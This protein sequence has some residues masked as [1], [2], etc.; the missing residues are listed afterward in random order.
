MTGLLAVAVDSALPLNGTED[1]TGLVLSARTIPHQDGYYGNG[2]AAVWTAQ[3]AT[4]QGIWS[5]SPQAD[6]SEPQSSIFSP[7]PGTE[8]HGSNQSRAAAQ[9]YFYAHVLSGAYRPSLNLY[10]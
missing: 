8:S 5:V 7:T 3:A 9:Y 6:Q 1:S 2:D 10:A 4:G